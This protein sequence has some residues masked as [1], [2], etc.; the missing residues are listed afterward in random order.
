MWFP[1]NQ[2]KAR[3]VQGDTAGSPLSLQTC[4]LILWQT[5]TRPTFVVI[6]S[7]ECILLW[8]CPDWWIDWSTI[9]T[10]EWQSETAANH[11]SLKTFTAWH[12]DIAIYRI[13]TAKQNPTETSSESEISLLPL[14]APVAANQISDPKK[15]P[16]LHFKKEV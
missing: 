16:S 3:K 13:H 2:S 15:T 10:T 7:P 8:N 11:R 12:H 6:G 5:C 14:I 1:A 4:A 9:H